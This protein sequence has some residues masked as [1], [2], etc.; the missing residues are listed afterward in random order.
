[1]PEN[2]KLLQLKMVVA[3]PSDVARERSIVEAVASELN[4]GIAEELGVQLKVLRWETDAFPGLNLDG[5][6]GLI[7]SILRIQDSDL[8]VGI[9]WKRFG[10]PVADAK[11]GTE[12]EIRAAYDSW[13]SSGRPQIMVY[14]NRKPYSATSKEELEQWGE[15][16]DFQRQFPED[17]LWWPYNGT[18]QFERLIRNHLT[19]FLRRWAAESSKSV[20]SD[21]T[22][23]LDAEHRGATGYELLPLMSEEIEKIVKAIIEPGL[24]RA[25]GARAGCK[26][27][28]ALYVAID[29]IAMTSRVFLDILAKEQDPDRLR[30]LVAQHLVLRQE[31]A[32]FAWSAEE[33]GDQL[34]IYNRELARAVRQL[35]GMKHMRLDFWNAVF[36]AAS[37]QI[38]TSRN[39]AKFNLEQFRHS[40]FFYHRAGQMTEQEGSIS[41]DDP[42]AVREAVSIGL[43]GISALESTASELAEFIKSNCEFADL[44][45]ARP[46]CDEH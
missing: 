3:S 37:Q 4:R 38:E 14:F 10:T 25:G 15:V 35:V 32:K 17:G 46:V 1:M 29:R 5:P 21:D 45:P 30:H 39:L 19:L 33:C 34:S 24:K 41:L 26:E 23:R 9:F 36:K 16:L 8:V 12:H 7:D 27:L 22:S 13:Y 20:A 43:H 6:Q 31:F 18:R 42:A 11:S 40:S 2:R 28:F 44:F